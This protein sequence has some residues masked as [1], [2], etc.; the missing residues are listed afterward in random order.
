M[1]FV[2]I[3]VLCFMME[4]YGNALFDL[5]TF[6]EW[7]RPV[8]ATATV[9]PCLSVGLVHSDPCR[10]INENISRCDPWIWRCWT[11]DDSSVRFCFDLQ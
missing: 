5:Y 3:L 8:N 1:N 4:F 9:R 10:N 7:A 11:R 6:P 2:C